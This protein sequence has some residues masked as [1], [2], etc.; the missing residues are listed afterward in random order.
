MNTDPLVRM[1]QETLVS[2]PKTPTNKE[3]PTRGMAGNFSET[4]HLQ[5]LAY[6]VVIAVIL[7]LAR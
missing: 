2:H 7:V 3:E 1:L 4:A 6:G 5:I